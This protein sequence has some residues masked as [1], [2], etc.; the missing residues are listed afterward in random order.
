MNH[1]KARIFL[2]K[3]LSITIIVTCFSFSVAVAQ[4]VSNSTPATSQTVVANPYVQFG[5][6]GVLVGILITILKKQDARMEERDK[7]AVKEREERDKAHADEREKWMN[8]IN[9]TQRL[10]AEAINKLNSTLSEMKGK[11]SS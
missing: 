9:D 3:C 5:A 2:S 7:M 1:K 11:I 4:E 8:M 6:L 10:E